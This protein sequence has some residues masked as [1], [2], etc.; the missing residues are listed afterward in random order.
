LELD[1]FYLDHRRSGELDGG[2][3][4]AVVWMQCECGA[5]IAHRD[6]EPE[7]S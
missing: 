1:A 4:G 5:S 7:T 2:V 6:S 3:E